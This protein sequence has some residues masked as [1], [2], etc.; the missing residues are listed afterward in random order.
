MVEA[1]LLGVVGG[2]IA[3]AIWDSAKAVMRRMR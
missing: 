3:N 2:L 1:L